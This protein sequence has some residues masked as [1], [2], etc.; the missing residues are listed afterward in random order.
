MSEHLDLEGLM[1]DLFS[2]PFVIGGLTV[3]RCSLCSSNAS[4]M[5]VMLHDAAEHAA[6]HVHDIAAL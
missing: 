4:T 1:A 5:A 3:V 6:L 2:D